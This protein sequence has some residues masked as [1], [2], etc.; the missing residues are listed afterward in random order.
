MKKMQLVSI[1]LVFSFSFYDSQAQIWQQVQK[2]PQQQATN[3]TS[4]KGQNEADKAAGQNTKMNDAI[5]NYDKNRVDASLVPD[6]YT[7]SWKYIMEIK[8]EEGKSIN[9]DYFL[10]P[11][12]TYFGL[13]F[14]HGQGPNM[15][16]IMDTKNNLT[17]NAFGNG[18]EKMASASKI[19]DYS[20]IANKQGEKSNFT[21]KTLPNKTILGYNCKGIQAT[22]DEYDIIYYYTNETKVSFGDMFKS[23]KNWKLPE[24]LTGYFKADEKTLLM[25]M[26]MKDLKKNG[27][28]T[29]M[30]C[31][32]L[33]K[34][35]FVFNKTDYTFM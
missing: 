13:N 8:N 15:V 11:N 24:G 23:Q 28:S 3:K 32:S 26:N 29:T 17:I 30:K 5:S 6:S 35:A 14:S 16:M 4:K 10:E 9:M 27:K 33:E 25:D 22:S 12:A 34:N 19:A 7:F 31:I 18:K 1:L 2:T 20:K 21:Y